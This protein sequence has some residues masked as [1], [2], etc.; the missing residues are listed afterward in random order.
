MTDDPEVNGMIAALQERVDN[1][2]T[3]D[4]HEVAAAMP[5]HW[6]PTRCGWILRHG[7]GLSMPEAVHVAK[8]ARGLEVGPTELSDAE[9]VAYLREC[10]RTGHWLAPNA[11]RVL[12]VDR[13]TFEAIVANHCT[14]RHFGIADAI[15]HLGL[16]FFNDTATTEIY[17]VAYDVLVVLGERDHLIANLD[18]VADGLQAVIPPFLREML[19]LSSLDDFDADQRREAIEAFVDLVVQGT[20][21]ATYAKMEAGLRKTTAPDNTMSEVMLGPG[22]HPEMA[23]TLRTVIEAEYEDDEGFDA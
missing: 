5:P 12:V 17:T 21:S 2:E 8:V 7:L 16:R 23:E 9:L 10:P 6:P 22:S 1:G 11:E 14:K 18:A 19:H 3:P 13:P 15:D 20:A 4:P